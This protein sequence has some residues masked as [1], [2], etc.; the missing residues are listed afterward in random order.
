EATSFEEAEQAFHQLGPPVVVKPVDGSAQRGVT[1]VRAEGELA[2][3]VDRALAASRSGALVLEQ[4]LDGDEF[5]V[6]GFLLDREYFPM[7]GTHRLLP[8]PP[9][10]G[11]RR[12]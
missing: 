10:L 7:S 6:N 3:A 8:P 11:V 2:G 1:E 4:Y 12:W 9:P 5:T